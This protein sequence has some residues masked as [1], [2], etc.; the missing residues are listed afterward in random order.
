[1]CV[2]AVSAVQ[3]SVQRTHTRGVDRAC[4]T[5]NERVVDVDPSM[6]DAAASAPAVAAAAPVVTTGAAVLNASGTSTAVVHLDA[7]SRRVLHEVC[8]GLDDPQLQADVQGGLVVVQL[9]PGLAVQARKDAVAAVV[10]K[11]GDTEEL[12]SQQAAAHVKQFAVLEAIQ[13]LM[14]VCGWTATIR[15]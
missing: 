5:V 10:K 4:S 14:E 12:E 9:Q 8:D 1:M 3:V 11:A 13:R 15:A 6:S 7:E 2:R